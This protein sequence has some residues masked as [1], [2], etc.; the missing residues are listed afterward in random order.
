MADGVPVVLVSRALGGAARPAYAFP[1][2]GVEWATAGA[3]FAGTLS[4]PK[5][6]VALALALGAGLDGGDLRALLEGT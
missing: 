6:R 3:L 1:G 5:A 4:A 2:G